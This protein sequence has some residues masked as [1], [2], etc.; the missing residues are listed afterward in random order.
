MT[1]K[2]RLPPSLLL[3]EKLI[4]LNFL[5]KNYQHLSIFRN[6]VLI[7]MLL[8]SVWTATLIK[9]LSITYG[10][11]LVVAMF[12]LL[13]LTVSRLFFWI[14]SSLLLRLLSWLLLLIF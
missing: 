11:V 7:Y 9:K 5:L 10:F 3:S 1:K 8:G 13:S 4:V 6:V 2:L 12:L 14:K